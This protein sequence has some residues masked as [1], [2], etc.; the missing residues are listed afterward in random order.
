MIAQEILLMNSHVC[1]LYTY[2]ACV[3]IINRLLTLRT[4]PYLYD[5]MNLSIKLIELIT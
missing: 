1:D 2:N 3:K 4:Q 5:I